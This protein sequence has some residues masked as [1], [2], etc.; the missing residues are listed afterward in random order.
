MTFC[1]TMKLCSKIQ[2]L[3]DYFVL[4]SSIVFMNS[5]IYIKINKTMLPRYR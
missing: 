5:L 4:K 1:Y 3:N 2:I